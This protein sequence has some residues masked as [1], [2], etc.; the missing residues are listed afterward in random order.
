[1]A[2]H[3][4]LK[5]TGTKMPVLGLG[6]W[7]SKPGEVY[8]ATKIAIDAGYRHIDEAWIYS[9]VSTQTTAD[10]RCVPYTPPKKT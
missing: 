9:Y 8:E 3:I 2:T 1:M 7:L 5:G 6:T 4:A 10:L